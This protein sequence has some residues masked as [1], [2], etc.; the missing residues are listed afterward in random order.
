MITKPATL[1]ELPPKSLY[2]V[3]RTCELLGISRATLAR[4]TKMGEILM[5]PRGFHVYYMGKDITKY[6]YNH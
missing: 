4:H 1:P 6:Y 5:T 3:R 2:N